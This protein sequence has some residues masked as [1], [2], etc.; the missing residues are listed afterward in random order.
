M[1]DKP[2]LIYVHG[3]GNQSRHTAAELKEAYDGALF[4]GPGPSEAVPWWQ[5]FWER[6]DGPAMEAQLDSVIGALAETPSDVPGVDAATLLTA[7]RAARPPIRE[8]ADGLE[9]AVGESETGEALDAIDGCYASARSLQGPDEMPD[10]I[11]KFL[12]GQASRDVVSYLYDGWKRRMREP[13][14]KRLRELG[15]DQPLVLLVHSLG[16][17]V[18]YD[19]VTDSEFLPYNIQLLVT[20]GTPLG[21]KNVRDKVRDGEG[22]GA[23]PVTVTGWQ[24]FHDSRDKVGWFG[25]TLL[26]KYPAPPPLTQKLNVINEQP[27]HHEL[28]G[29]LADLDLR[30]VVRAALKI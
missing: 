6:P 18:A 17:I 3:A 30:A 12:A 26:G 20:A 28:T 15:K 11:F 2:L 5:V 29:Y 19:V 23:L 27:D 13:L 7:I 9:E 24:N 4:G 25:E 10:P 14:K 16:S 8:A 22:P 21:I 1:A